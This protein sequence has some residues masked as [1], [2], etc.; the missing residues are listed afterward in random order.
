[1]EWM[2]ARE[3]PWQT[4]R[5]SQCR[6]ENFPGSPPRQVGRR[7]AGVTSVHR[8]LVRCQCGCAVVSR[9]SPLTT[10]NC[11]CPLLCLLHSTVVFAHICQQN[12]KVGRRGKCS[13][14]A[15]LLRYRLRGQRLGDVAALSLSTGIADEDVKLPRPPRVAEQLAL[16]V[17]NE[18]S[19]PPRI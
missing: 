15:G 9:Q 8:A 3:L 19:I 16:L 6:L 4:N 18:C 14:A 11:S 7:R 10:T 13:R 5:H 17:F 12:S 2:S 1:M